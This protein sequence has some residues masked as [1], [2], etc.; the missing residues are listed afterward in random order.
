MKLGPLPRI[1]K[2]NKAASKKSVKRMFSLKVTFYLTKT[3]N[4]TK[5]SLT[6]LSHN[7]VK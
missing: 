6:H 4:R 2:R 3:G 1:E 7:C 5:K